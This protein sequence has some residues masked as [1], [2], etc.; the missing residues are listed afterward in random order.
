MAPVLKYSSRY[1]KIL[2]ST[3]WIATTPVSAAMV[4]L[5]V[6]SQLK[7]GDRCM[8]ACLEMMKGG[9]VLPTMNLTVC[10]G[11][12]R[13]CGSDMAVSCVWMGIR[14][15]MVGLIAWGYQCGRDA[16]IASWTHMPALKPI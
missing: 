5:E 15:Q 13:C 12:G 7:Y 1:L 2:G 11:G 10:G 8:T 4:S 3:S 6:K 14:C 16:L 9:Y